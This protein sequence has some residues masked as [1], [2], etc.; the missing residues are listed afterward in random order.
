MKAGV[1]FSSMRRNFLG[2]QKIDSEN[3]RQDIARTSVLKLL[4]ADQLRARSNIDMKLT[5]VCSPLSNFGTHFFPTFFQDDRELAMAAVQQNCGLL[6][7]MQQSIANNRPA[8]A[9]VTF[10]LS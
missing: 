6:S 8:M 5:I 4:V 3:C 9:E 10:S 2:L 1:P 7:T